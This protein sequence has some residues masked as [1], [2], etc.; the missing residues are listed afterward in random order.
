MDIPVI[1]RQN[2]FNKS[3]DFLYSLVIN[4]IIHRGFPKLIKTKSE[5]FYKKDL[6]V[7]RSYSY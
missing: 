2:G 5:E 6:K 1:T 7:K 4:K 3:T